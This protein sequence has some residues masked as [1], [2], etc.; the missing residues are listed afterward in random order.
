M[1]IV[2]ASAV[3]SLAFFALIAVFIAANRLNLESGNRVRASFL[4]EEGLEVLRFLRDDSWSQNL[5][6]LSPSTDYFLA[7]DTPSSGWSINSV[8][9]EVID[10]LFERKFTVEDVERNSSDDIV[11]SGGT[12]DPDTKKFNVE[13]SWEERG[14][15][16]IILLSTYLSDVYDE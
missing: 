14:T 9:L 10:G 12:V 2:V 1:E 7:F 8:T 3:I 16:I 6:S 11:V 4:V 13:V 15:T 5:E